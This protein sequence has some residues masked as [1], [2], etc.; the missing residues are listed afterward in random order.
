M[1]NYIVTADDLDGIADFNLDNYFYVKQGVL[2]SNPVIDPDLEYVGLHSGG[3]AKFFIH[4]AIAAGTGIKT[5]TQ[6]EPAEGSI[7][8]VST[9]GSITGNFLPGGAPNGYGVELFGDG[10][11]VDNAGYI[12]AD[13]SGIKVTGS[14]S[15]Y[16][17]GEIHAAYAV[18]LFAD[19]GSG[20]F[21]V[22]N[23]GL[24]YGLVGLNDATA[25]GSVFTIKNS[26]EIEQIV[27]ETSTT[28]SVA[29]IT[30][31]GLIS[32]QVILGSGADVLDNRN[33]E[34]MSDVK[35]GLGADT[36][37]NANGLVTGI[38]YGDEG[39]V[40]VGGADS[41]YGGASD[42][43]FH[44]DG[45]NDV[46]RG[47]AGD[48]ELFGD[49]GNDT[50][51]GEAGFD[52]LD[53]GLGNDFA[54]YFYDSAIVLALDGSLI[55]SGAVTQDTLISIESISG[56]NI[57]ADTLIGD[58]QDNKLYGNGGVD[59]INGNAGT[60]TLRGGV[61]ADILNGNSG[62]DTYQYTA[63]TEGGDFVGSFSSI[64]FFAFRSSA[65]G[66]LTVGGLDST[67]FQ[68]KATDNLALDTNDRFIFRESDDTLW[69]DPTGSTNGATDAVLIAD[70]TVNA[71]VS[72][73]D[74]T[75]FA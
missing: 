75:I 19:E 61:G 23:S 42:E 67:R 37:R 26:G 60:D 27:S 32:G 35:L 62:A 20:S 12:G 68:S 9:T 43:I 50:L 55:S 30:N 51:R 36:F 57:G 16:N 8:K 46:L 71:V 48:D 33:G 74:I 64:D 72:A 28:G 11:I 31:T 54:S 1:T 70:I 7:V 2:V 56:S 18:K 65:F 22:I 29:L 34:I 3:G 53:G 40:T 13:D 45:G 39:T 63:T 44:G 38:V 47:G 5:G 58:A 17:S 25:T 52:T 10:H 49:D 14:G 21:N 69:Y 66:N 24:M 59:T 6:A 15:I 41:F 73:G 4:G